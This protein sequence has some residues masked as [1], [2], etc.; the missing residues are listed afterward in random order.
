M[1]I[2]QTALH[3]QGS[4]LSGRQDASKYDTM[5]LC[6]QIETIGDAINAVL[7]LL[8]GKTVFFRP[9]SPLLTNGVGWQIS[10]RRVFVFV[11]NKYF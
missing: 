11:G 2:F 8:R 9:W 3:R 5:A 4:R 1:E 7:G 10:H 6:E